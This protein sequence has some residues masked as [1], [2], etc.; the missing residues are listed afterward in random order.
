MTS[1]L[2]AEDQGWRRLDDL[3]LEPYKSDD[4][5]IPG[6]GFPTF[7]DTFSGTSVDTNK[8]RR[9][10]EW[11]Q[12]DDSAYIFADNAFVND[13]K[14]VMRTDY[15]G[16][17]PVAGR[18]WGTAYVDT[19]G[20]FSQRYGRFE[21]RLKALRPMKS[22]GIWPAFWLR[23]NSGGG[24][25]DIY[26]A[27]GTPCNY[28][29]SYPDN[30]SGFSCTMYKQT[31]TGTVGVDRTQNYLYTLPQPYYDYH[32]FTCIWTPDG[33]TN[34]CDGVKTLEVLSSTPLGAQIMAGFPTEAHI[35][36]SQHVGSNWAGHPDPAFN[37]TDNPNDTLIDYV[38]VWA[39][40]G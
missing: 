32:T 15:R 26:E 30:G 28:P 4:G 38:R 2:I 5:Y 10:Q 16:T 13:G 37:D 34:Y 18:E 36:I 7:E 23:D 12:T 1:L 35:R 29:S 21:I 25:N 3:V 24:E 20:K 8:W 31:G 6:W 19:I 39:W 40:G 9:R 27:V 11:I 14:M 17:T 33:M 22:R